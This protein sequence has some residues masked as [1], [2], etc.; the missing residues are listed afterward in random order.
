M[1]IH[2]AR[3]ISVN[4]GLFLAVMREEP[5]LLLLEVVLVHVPKVGLE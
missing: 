1:N 2:R 3:A 4:Q 5:G